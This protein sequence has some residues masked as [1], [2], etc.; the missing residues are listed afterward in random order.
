MSVTAI[1]NGNEIPELRYLQSIVLPGE[2]GWLSPDILKPAF[3][4]S[5]LNL[6][7]LSLIRA[8]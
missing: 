7:V 8:A 4:I 1:A 6:F 5:V 3:V 2:M